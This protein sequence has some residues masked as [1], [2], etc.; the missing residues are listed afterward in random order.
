[1]VRAINDSGLGSAFE[2]HPDILEQI[3]RAVSV[4]GAVSHLLRDL[5][6]RLLECTPRQ[7]EEL[8]GSFP[9]EDKRLRFVM[10]LISTKPETENLLATRAVLG[11]LKKLADERNLI[12]HGAPVSGS[13]KGVRPRSEYFLNM[14]KEDE[15][16]RYVDARTMLSSHLV[17]LKRNGGQLF[18][19]LHPEP[20]P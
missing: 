18:D 12:V 20:L 4:W 5:V 13:K 19:L 3:G 1:M 9:G 17:K 7:A 15:A 11:R 6:C 2:Q 14:R 16:D 10:E 8:L